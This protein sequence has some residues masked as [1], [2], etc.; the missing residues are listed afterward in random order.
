M[1]GLACKKNAICA[2]GEGAQACLAHSPTAPNEK[3]FALPWLITGQIQK[4][5]RYV[6]SKQ[7]GKD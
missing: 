7:E 1:Q 3:N 5:S 6:L 4:T 2:V